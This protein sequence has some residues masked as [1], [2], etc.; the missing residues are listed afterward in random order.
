MV[1]VGRVHPPPPP[2]LPTPPPPPSCRPPP[3][4]TAPPPPP[5]PQ[6][7][8]DSWGG[9]ASGPLVVA[10]PG[11]VLRFCTTTKP[12]RAS[13]GLECD[14]VPAR[15]RTRM[16]DRPGA[17]AVHFQP[18]PPPPRSARM[19]EALECGPAEWRSGP[20]GLCL[21]PAG[22]G[23]GR[24]FSTPHFFFFAEGPPLRTPSPKGLPT[25]NRQ[26]PTANRHQ[27][28]TANRQPSP[29]VVNHMNST[30]SFCK[31]AVSDNLFFSS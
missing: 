25:A 19:N 31:T 16:A 24:S 30:R 11:L 18:N 13:I 28:P 7:L 6:V 9:V 5:P 21:G 29:T 20:A 12:A 2:E 3:A 17:R 8:A 15:H 23:P 14:C 4:P 27:L 26:L 22:V 10:P 1:V